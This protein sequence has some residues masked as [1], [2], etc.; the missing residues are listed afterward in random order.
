MGIV[1]TRLP[2]DFKSDNL[3]EA[4][5]LWRVQTIALNHFN[6]AE[7][8]LNPRARTSRRTRQTVT[9]KEKRLIEDVSM[10]SFHVTMKNH[11]NKKGHL[12]SLLSVNGLPTVNST[13]TIKGAHKMEN[14]PDEHG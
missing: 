4:R 14:V 9:T 5:K 12:I 11:V 7:K 1:D 8:S 10:V 2:H 13:I 6:Q 3:K